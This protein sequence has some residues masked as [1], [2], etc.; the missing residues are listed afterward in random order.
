MVA[1]RSHSFRMQ[2]D[3]LQV[4]DG[5]SGRAPSELLAHGDRQTRAGNFVPTTPNTTGSRA[6]TWHFVGIRAAGGYLSPDCPLNGTNPPISL[7]VAPSHYQFVAGG[8]REAHGFANRRATSRRSTLA[9]AAF[10][11]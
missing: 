1:G 8:R 10:H 3:E 6:D 4:R 2:V 7:W 5:C 11:T 9:L